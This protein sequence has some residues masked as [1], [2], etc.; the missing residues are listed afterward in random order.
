VHLSA[1]E[2]HTE[3]LLGLSGD[4]LRLLQQAVNDMLSQAQGDRRAQLEA[5]A[6]RLSRAIDETER[7]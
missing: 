6:T 5:V 4:A 1:T 2:V 7:S 3:A